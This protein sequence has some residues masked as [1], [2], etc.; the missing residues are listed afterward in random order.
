MVQQPIGGN[1]LVLK[2]RHQ[3]RG[4][5]KRQQVAGLLGGKSRGF[6]R[7]KDILVFHTVQS[8]TKSVLCQVFLPDSLAQWDIRGWGP[9]FGLVMLVVVGLA[10]D[11]AACLTA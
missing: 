1:A 2:L 11:L 6:Q 8:T 3:G 10:I 9:A 5:D 7:L 4:V